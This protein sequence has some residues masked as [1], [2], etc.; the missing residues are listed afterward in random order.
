MG[1]HLILSEVSIPQQ[2]WF[3]HQ[4]EYVLE[5]LYLPL[6]NKQKKNNILKAREDEGKRDNSHIC[7]IPKEVLTLFLE[8]VPSSSANIVTTRVWVDVL[9][10]DENVCNVA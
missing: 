3:H 2:S 7:L 4:S 9:V 5:F 6:E 1:A 8:V 10:E